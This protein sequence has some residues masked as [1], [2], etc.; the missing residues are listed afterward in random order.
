MH[1]PHMAAL[2]FLS[3]MDHSHMCIVIVFSLDMYAALVQVC[4]LTAVQQAAM[5][6]YLHYIMP[7]APELAAV[8]Q[9]VLST[10][11]LRI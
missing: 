4:D 10:W 11:I 2:S 9:H 7:R 6:S 3:Y 8:F 1:N 5:W